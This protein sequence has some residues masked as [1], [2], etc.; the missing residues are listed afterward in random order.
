M[1]SE[2]CIRDRPES[3]LISEWY[4]KPSDVRQNDDKRRRVDLRSTIDAPNAALS[5]RSSRPEIVDPASVVAQIHVENEDTILVTRME[6][7]ADDDG[8]NC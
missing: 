8:A 1:G 7:Q 6:S 3:V 2:M 5:P 4:F